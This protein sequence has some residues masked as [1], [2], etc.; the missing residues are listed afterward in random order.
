MEEKNYLVENVICE[1]LDSCKI[2][3]G[4]QVKCVTLGKNVVI[5]EDSYVTNS[6]FGDY[7]Q[8]NRRNQIDD[9][10]IG[11]RTYTGANT[12]LHH[13]EIGKYTSISWNVSLGGA[14]R[15]HYDRIALH[16]FMQL[17]QFGLVDENEEINFPRTKFGNDVWIGMAASI[18]SG[19]TLGDGAVIGAG[20]VVTKDVPPYAIVVGSPA[21]IY[22]YRFDE[23]T[24][25]KLLK[26]KW[27][28]W[29]EAVIRENIHIF[30]HSL[31]EDDLNIIQDIYER[32]IAE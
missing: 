29:P 6:V 15:H 32:Q 4:A 28:D 1:A 31:S 16:P 20:S 14:A 9:V 17:K 7:V 24:I 22:K 19:I 5:G 11:C 8:I 18:I 26:W 25:E 27:W 21:R 10:T 13:A 3:Q 2:Y 23:I 12:S 30:R